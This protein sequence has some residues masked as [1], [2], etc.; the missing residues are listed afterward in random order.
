MFPLLRTLALP[1]G[2]RS[3]VFSLFCVC[4]TAFKFLHRAACLR[5]W[6]HAYAFRSAAAKRNLHFQSAL[7]SVKFGIA[8]DTVHVHGVCFL[9]LVFWCG[10]CALQCSAFAALFSQATGCIRFRPY[11]KEFRSA[12]D[13][14][15]PSL[16][17]F[18]SVTSMVPVNDGC[19]L[20]LVFCVDFCI[21]VGVRGWKDCVSEI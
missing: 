7:N 10:I 6:P 2:A 21:E 5:S 12:A 1:C 18:G 15:I 8:A 20:I 9:N 16:N 19:F 4:C 3:S 13:E 14:R 11:T 17:S